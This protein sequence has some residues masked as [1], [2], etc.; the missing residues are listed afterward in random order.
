MANNSSTHGG[1]QLLPVVSFL[2]H[3]NT[4]VIELIQFLKL[5]KHY[6][7]CLWQSFSFYLTFL[8]IGHVVSICRSSSGLKPLTFPL[9]W[10]LHLISVSSRSNSFFCLPFNRTSSLQIQ[11]FV[12]VFFVRPAGLVF[13]LIHHVP[14][15]RYEGK[16]SEIDLSKFCFRLFQHTAHLAIAKNSLGRNSEGNL[17][18]QIIGYRTYRCE[19]ISKF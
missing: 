13:H 17:L 2:T 11:S 19:S 4:Q 18:L 6:S 8:L 15:I 1:W 14:L 16:A 3:T 5:V 10:A 9:M 7:R 12:K